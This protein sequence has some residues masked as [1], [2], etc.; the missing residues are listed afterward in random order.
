MPFTAED[1]LRVAAGRT[2]LCGGGLDRAYFASLHGDATIW[3]SVA[4]VASDSGGEPHFYVL[5]QKNVLGSLASGI[6]KAILADVEAYSLNNTIIEAYNAQDIATWAAEMQIPA[7]IVHAT[8]TAQVPAF[9]ELYRTVKENRLH[10]SD[11]LEGLAR[12]METFTYELVNGQPRFGSDRWHDDRVYSLAWAIH[13]LRQQELAAYTLKNII[14]ESKSPHARLC[15][16][17]QGD[18]ILACSEFCPS[19]KKVKLMHLQHRSNRVE[20]DLTLP[21]FFKSMVKIGGFTLLE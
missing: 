2:Y 19:H 18:V 16:M 20:S 5:N 15:Y 11:K 1:V 21:D 6:K 3:T 14:C 8:N 12:E 13:S 17:R 10:F 4:K 7:E 9:M